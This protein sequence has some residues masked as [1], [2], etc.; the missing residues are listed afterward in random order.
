VNSGSLERFGIYRPPTSWQRA[1]V[2]AE[3][4]QAHNSA[5]IWIRDMPQPLNPPGSQLDLF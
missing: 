4:I 2:I 5:P 1:Q 3:R